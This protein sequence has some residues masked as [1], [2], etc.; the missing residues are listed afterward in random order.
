LKFL[1]IVHG[2]ISQ[3]GE[4]PEGANRVKSRMLISAVPSPNAQF[5]QRDLSFFERP[6]MKIPRHDL[7]F[8]YRV[9]LVV[10]MLTWRIFSF[11]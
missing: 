5:P 1:N 9:I 7:S 4:L 2:R 3:G 10:P 6:F 8:W 11:S